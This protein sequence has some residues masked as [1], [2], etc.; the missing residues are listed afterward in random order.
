MCK[1]CILESSCL[2]G[3]SRPWAFWVQE[4]R[5]VDPICFRIVDMFPPSERKIIGFGD[6]YFPIHRVLPLERQIGVI[7]STVLGTIG[8]NGNTHKQIGSSKQIGSTEQIGSTKQIGSTNQ[9]GSTKQTVP[10]WVRGQDVGGYECGYGV[11][12]R[13]WDWGWVLGTGC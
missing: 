2:P 13:L 4:P 9:I 11:G 5:L 10:R 12:M 3:V 7:G 1:A 6:P 8:S